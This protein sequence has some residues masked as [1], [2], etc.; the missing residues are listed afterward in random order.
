MLDGLGRKIV[1]EFYFG[2]ILGSP[3]GRTR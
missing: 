2:A 3:Q 1:A